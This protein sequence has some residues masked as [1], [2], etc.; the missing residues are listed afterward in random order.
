MGFEAIINYKFCARHIYRKADKSDLWI[1]KQKNE[2][3]RQ[4]EAG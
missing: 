2:V 3:A 1:K 4:R